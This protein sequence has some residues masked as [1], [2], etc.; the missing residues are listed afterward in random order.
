MAQRPNSQTQAHTAARAGFEAGTSLAMRRLDRMYRQYAK[1]LARQIRLMR[2]D[3]ATPRGQVRLQAFI[4]QQ[5]ARLAT[6]LQLLI[7]AHVTQASRTAMD[8]A[9][10]AARPALT[11]VFG[12]EQVDRLFTRLADQVAKRHLNERE[13]ERMAKSAA[14]YWKSAAEQVARY[15]NTS[16]PPPAQLARTMQAYLTPGNLAVKKQLHQ[17]AGAPSNPLYAGA[18]LAETELQTSYHAATIEA[19]Q[20]TPAYQGISWHLSG[21]HQRL[22]ICDELVGF[23][24]AGEEPDKPHPHCRCIIIPKYDNASELAARLRRWQR[25][26]SSEPG[27]ESWYLQHAAEL[28]APRAAA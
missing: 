23:H 3:P 21:R 15:A 16:H 4:D 18:R 1:E 5:A 8:G 9:A 22:D 28:G 25:D 20:A 19:G 2:Y 10:E 13:V 27:I 6:S 17:D 12:P 11:A 24:P 26:R 14:D 7:Q